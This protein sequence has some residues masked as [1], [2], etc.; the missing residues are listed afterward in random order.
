MKAYGAEIVLTDGALGMKGA[1]DK[2]NELAKDIE[3]SFIPSQFDNP[4]NPLAHYK[5]TAREIWADTVS[6]IDIFVAGV[7]TEWYFKWYSEVP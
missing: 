3:N 7:G 1:I 5:Y 2:A 4:N 6:N